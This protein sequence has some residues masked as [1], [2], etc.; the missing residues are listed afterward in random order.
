[1]LTIFAAKCNKTHINLL[2]AGKCEKR[3]VR[4]HGIYKLWQ[5]LLYLH[6]GCLAMS[7]LFSL[8]F[9]FCRMLSPNKCCSLQ[10]YSIMYTIIL[11]SVTLWQQCK[12]SERAVPTL[13]KHMQAV[14][15]TCQQ[16]AVVFSNRR[17]SSLLT[18][19]LIFWYSAAHSWAPR[20][21]SLKF[22]PQEGDS[23][24]VTT[25]WMPWP[26]KEKSL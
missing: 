8:F 10:L 20:S 5:A 11:Q 22:P 1:M 18:F 19:C 2:C 24:S 3:H 4:Y 17:H 14:G 13:Q 16:Y 6:P 25:M 12:Q 21:C 26:Y 15:Q 23:D 9:S 7:Q